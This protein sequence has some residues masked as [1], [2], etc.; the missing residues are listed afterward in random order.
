MRNFA[1]FILS[2]S[3]LFCMFLA[4]WHVRDCGGITATTILLAAASG[5]LLGV[6]DILGRR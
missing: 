3:G 6:S 1:A 2:S 4:G 5:V